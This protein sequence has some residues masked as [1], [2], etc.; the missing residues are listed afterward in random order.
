M[1]N[2]TFSSVVGGGRII[3]SKRTHFLS[4]YSRS[5]FTLAARV[6]LKTFILPPTPPPYTVNISLIRSIYRPGIHHRSFKLPARIH[7]TLSS[8]VAI[9]STK[10]LKQ[11]QGGGVRSIVFFFSPHPEL[12]TRSKYILE[13][14]RLEW[15]RTSK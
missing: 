5:Y 15:Q 14:C 9:F 12:I 7:Q 6:R 10:N 2:L 8:R 1:S 3:V 4:D 11:T 13:T